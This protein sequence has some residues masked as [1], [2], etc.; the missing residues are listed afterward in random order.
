MERGD[1]DPDMA[2]VGE[3]HGRPRV[4][5]TPG[6]IIGTIDL[7]LGGDGVIVDDTIADVADLKERRHR[8]RHRSSFRGHR[9]VGA[10]SGG[11][12][13]VA[14]PEGLGATGH[15]ADITDERAAGRV[16][17]AIGSL[18]ALVNNAGLERLTRSKRW[19]MPASPSSAG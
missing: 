6:T 14:L 1:I 16:M 9:R 15:R 5:A 12:P 7:S 13:G 17:D 3:H 11:R 4:D 18:D 2:T 19:T 10:C 8:C